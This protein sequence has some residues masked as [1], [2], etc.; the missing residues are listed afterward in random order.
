MNSSVQIF[1]SNKI[2][3]HLCITRVSSPRLSIGKNSQLCI[4]KV[5]RQACAPEACEGTTKTMSCRNQL[6][7]GMCSQLG[8][9]NG[10]DSRCNAVVCNQKSRMRLC[11][12][13]I[14]DIGRDIREENDIDIFVS[15]SVQKTTHIV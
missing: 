9:D 3:N 2:L 6:V 14:C 11:P 13:D 15:R 1:C 4:G 7:V 12:T 8:A 10:Q 5:C